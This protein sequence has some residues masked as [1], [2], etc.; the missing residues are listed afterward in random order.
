MSEKL[1]SSLEIDQES[2][3]DFRI[4]LLMRIIE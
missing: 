3:P 2:H 4:D 1:S